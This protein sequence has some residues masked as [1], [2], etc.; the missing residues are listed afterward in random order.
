VRMTLFPG[1]LFPRLIAI[2]PLLFPLY[3]MKGEPFGIP[4]T[5]PEVVLGFAFVYFLIREEIFTKKWLH[6][7]FTMGGTYQIRPV[8]LFVVAAAIGVYVAPGMSEFLDGTEFPAKMRALGIFKGWVIAPIVYFF[9]ARFYFLEK[10][11]MIPLALR[12]LLLSGII[13]SIYAIIQVY[14]GDFITPDMR[15]SGPFES[16]NFLAMYLGPIFIFAVMALVGSKEMLDRFYLAAGVILCGIAIYFTQSYSAWLAVAVTLFIGFGLFLRE[17]KM[18][19]RVL[20]AF[21]ITLAV[22][23]LVAT[24]YQTDKFQQFMELSERSSSSVRLEVYEISRSLLIQYPLQGIGLGQFEQVYQTR[25]VE[26]L[27][28][29]PFEWVMTHPH[30]IFLAMWLNMGILGLIAFCWL[31][32]YVYPWLFGRDNK[33]RNIVAYMILAIVVHG[34]FDTPYF[35]ND[36]SFEFW[37]LM[38]MLI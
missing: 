26:I 25:A 37:L 34:L 18:K 22:G 9:M 20:A 32:A 27:G 17:Q 2:F 29:A 10:P 24:Q 35:K 33:E 12:S 14:T 7:R 13:L 23:A 30:N 6:N 8:I 4:V 11:S 15:A 28:H 3:L 5:L 1:G 21:L 38:A 36:L 19:Y 16:A 31:L